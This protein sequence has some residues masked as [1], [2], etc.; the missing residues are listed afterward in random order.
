LEK[1]SIKIEKQKKSC[2][3]SDGEEIEEDEHEKLKGIK[4]F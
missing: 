4:L 3:N 2:L 1:A